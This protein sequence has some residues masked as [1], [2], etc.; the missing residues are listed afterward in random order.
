MEARTSKV[1]WT[2]AEFARLPEE[3]GVRHEVIA[4]ELH[5]TPAPRPLHQRVVKAFLVEID[6]FVE[7]NRLGE[8]FPGPVDVILAEGDYLEPDLVFVRSGRAGMVSDRGIEGAP[9]LVVEIASPS[10][11]ARDRGIKRDRYR[12]HGVPEYW[13][14]DPDERTLEVWRLSEGDLEPRVYTA[15]E[16]LVW[17]PT[18]PG[19]SLELSVGDLLSERRR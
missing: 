6:A 2:W 5:V 19:P 10:T 16:T 15:D 11:A 1:R 14:A 13:V 7:A 4:D 17:T 8:V 9:D 12:R 18:E 3:R